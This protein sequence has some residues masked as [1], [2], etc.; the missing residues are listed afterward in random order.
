MAMPERFLSSAEEQAM[1]DWLLTHSPIA[2]AVYDSELRCLAQNAEM[3]RLTGLSQ[4]DSRG[5]PFSWM[6]RG[7]DATAWERQMRRMF[8]TGEP[9][10]DREICG[11]TAADAEQDHVFAT[12]ASLLHDRRGRVCGVCTTVDDIT[13]QHRARERLNLLNEAS[14]GIGTTLD[15]MRTAQEL[16]DAAVPRLADW[17]TVDLLDTVLNGD[18]PG[19]FTGTVAL[20]RMANRSIIEGNPEAVRQP[21]EV[22]FYPPHSPPVLCMAT[23]RSALHRTTDPI[24]QSWLAVDPIRAERFRTYKFTTVMPVPVSARG[25]ILGVTIFFRRSTELFTDED[26]LLAEKLVALAAV[27][28]DNA[29]R[30][31]RERT[32]ALTLQHSLLPRRLPRQAAVEI[33]SRYLPSGGRTSVGGDWFDVIPLSGA[34]VALVVGDVVGHGISAAATMGRLRTAVRSL[35]DVD[36][37]PDELLTRLDDLV[38]P[39]GGGDDAQIEAAG[40]AATCLYAI[41]D[42]VSRRCCIARAGHPPPVVVTPDGTAGLLDLPAGPPLGLGSLPFESVEVELAEGSTLALYTDGLINYRERDMDEALK[43]FCRTLATPAIS[44]EELCDIVLDEVLPPHPLDDVALLVAR[45]RALSADQVAVLDVPA[46]PAAVGEARAWA[47]RRLAAWGLHD[48]LFA[49]EVVVSELVTNAIR[50]AHAPIRLRLIRDRRLIC[51]VSDASNTAPHMRRARVFD[52]GGRGLLLVAQLTE[53]WGARHTREGKT[54]WCEQLL[55]Q[56]EP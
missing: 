14:T 5:K 56:E 11:Q 34:R 42:P 54:I 31:S 41:Y 46:D 37:P 50:H 35:A 40:L 8:D 27:C 55:S 21:G 12:S 18:E 51:E 38:T 20:R 33:A 9:V 16:A 7:A 49:T 22:D 26:R 4:A 45:T 19:P 10:H 2:V 28:L 53:R 47:A 17:V 1:L 24:M 36:L 13:E 15:L 48:V 25:T 32:A 6:I 52:E 43:R 30:F 44:A 23:G 3:A 29:R 39:R